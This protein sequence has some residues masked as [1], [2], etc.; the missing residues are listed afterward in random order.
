M[1]SPE[2]RALVI[3]LNAQCVGQLREQNGLWALDYDA[4][5]QASVTG[6]DL[7][8]SLPRKAGSIVDGAI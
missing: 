8:P 6:F 7:A 2:A 4:E 5:W 3:W 1:S